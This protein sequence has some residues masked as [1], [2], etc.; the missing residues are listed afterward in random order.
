MNAGAP[1]L[2][3]VFIVGSPRR[4]GNSARLAD[5]LGEAASATAAARGYE[6][7]VD[8][9]TPATD[10]I[11][12]C[13]GCGSC[14]RTGHCVIVD[15]MPAAYE[16]IDR[17]DC[18]VWV[19]PVYFGS[20]PSQLKGFI[21]RFQ[22]FWAR[23]EARAR[24]G[25]QRPYHARRPG[26]AVLVR[27]GGDPFGEACALVPITAASN[28]AEVTLG[29]PVVVLGPDAAGDVM[30]DE[31]ARDRERACSAV[32]ELIDSALVWTQQEPT[33]AAGRTSLGG[34]FDGGTA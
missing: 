9:V 23:R 12:G 30:S 21:D 29:A 22:V 28:L 25:V 34:L 4:A 27:G 18:L 14:S 13:T 6:L 7:L 33:P 19:T 3:M 11:G 32:T 26:L 1:Q 20:V 8:T 15:G 16:L 10:D 2:R 31:F 24:A 17:A 5:L